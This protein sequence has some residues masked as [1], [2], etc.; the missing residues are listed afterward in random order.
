MTIRTN[1]IYYLEP[2]GANHTWFWGMDYASGDL[3]EAEELYRDGHKV[4]RNRCIYVR[5]PDGQVIEPIIAE[6]GQYLGRPTICG[7]DKIYQ[8]LVDFANKEINIMCF[9]PDEILKGTKVK[10][11]E[12]LPLSIT[13]DCYN[14]MLHTKPLI[15]TRQSDNH[16][17][18]L[19]AETDGRMEIDFAI[20]RCESFA[21]MQDEKL[22][23]HSWW[24]KE[25]PE[26][27]YHEEVIVRNYKGEVL[28]KNDGGL[29]EIYPGQYWIL[30]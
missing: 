11:V 4:K 23:F 16:F 6:E 25:E 22:Y 15:M 17:Q 13:E 27:E 26:Y 12:K 28:E 24:E 7:E 2:L 3:Y 19:W 21:F 5:Y 1:G 29:C 30:K 14:L 20:D 8:L 9:N 10:K 18:L